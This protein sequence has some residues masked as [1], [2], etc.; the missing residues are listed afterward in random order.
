VAAGRQDRLAAAK[1]IDDLLTPDEQ[2]A[3]RDAVGASFR[4]RRAAMMGGPPQGGPP[5]GGRFAPS[6]G[7]F[8][9]MV[10]LSRDQMRTTQPRARSISGSN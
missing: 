2:K 10:S 7:R 9:L 4:A 1:A 5:Q 6:A 3:V 8:L